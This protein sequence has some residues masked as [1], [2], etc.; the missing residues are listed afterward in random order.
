MRGDL[1]LMWK[2]YIFH[3]QGLAVYVKDGLPFE[4]DLPQKHSVESYL[5]F[6][7]SFTL[8]SALILFP[9]FSPLFLSI[10]LSATVFSLETSTSII[11]T[12]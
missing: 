3:M 11:R 12:G 2:D 6:S 1:P 7:T 4:Q 10:N 5:C 8:L 9:L